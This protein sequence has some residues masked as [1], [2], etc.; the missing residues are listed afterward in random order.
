LQ[1]EFEQHR[2]RSTAPNLPVGAYVPPFLK[3]KANDIETWVDGKIERRT[4]V[5]HGVAAPAY[6]FE[7]D[8]HGP[9]RL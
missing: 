3:I 7:V 9:T 4:L 8:E 1:A 2:Q 5:I 6:M